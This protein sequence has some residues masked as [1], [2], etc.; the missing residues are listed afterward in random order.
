MK[1]TP[2]RASVVGA[3]VFALL[4]AGALG[5][6]A[7]RAA[8]V[9]PV[10]ELSRYVAVRGVNESSDGAV[11]G[12]VVNVSSR[13]VKEVELHITHEW[14]WKNEFHPGEDNPGRLGTITLHDEIAPGGEARFSYRPDPPL[15]PRTDGHFVTKVDVA[16]LTAIET[17]PSSGATSGVGAPPAPPVR[18]PEPY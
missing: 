18:S 4:V 16:G 2:I 12:T 17:A 5:A 11:S 7:L 1:P 10:G 6:T 13:P 14:L 8:E 3:R 15:P 9:V